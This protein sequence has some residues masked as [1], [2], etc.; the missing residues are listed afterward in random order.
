MK[1]K[2]LRQQ[3]HSC[4]LHVLIL[5]FGT[6]L[7]VVPATAQAPASQKDCSSVEIT[8]PA[9]VDAGEDMMCSASVNDPDFTYHWATSTGDIISGQG[10]FS[11]TISNLSAGQNV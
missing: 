10:S 11:V 8:C 1:N 2:T 9:S 4:R 6:F 5:L 3:L 7:I